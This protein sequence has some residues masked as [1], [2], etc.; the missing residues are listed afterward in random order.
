MKLWGKLRRDK[1]GWVGKKSG[2]FSLFVENKRTCQKVIEIVF[3][4]TKLF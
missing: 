2:V 4:K 3:T 1:S